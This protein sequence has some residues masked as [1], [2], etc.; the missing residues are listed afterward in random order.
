MNGIIIYNP[1][2]LFINPVSWHGYAVDFALKYA[3][4]VFVRNP[5]KKL[6]IKNTVKGLC[7]SRKIKVKSSLF[8]LNKN[9]Y[10]I[11]GFGAVRNPTFSLKMY[12]GIKI[13]HLL[14]YYLDVPKIQKFL[15]KSKIDYVIGHCQMDEE[16]TFFRKYYKEYIGKVIDLPFG[17]AERFKYIRPFKDRI[18][19]AVGLGSIN[20]MK[21]ALL[22]ESQTKEMVEFFPLREYQ[23]EVRK[24]LQDNQQIVK[25]CIDALF[26]SPDKQKDFSYDAVEMLNKYQMFVNDAGFSNF[27]PARTYEG[28]A[29]GCVMVAPNNNIY[30]KLGFINDYNYIGYQEGNYSDMIKKIRYY[31]VH[32]A[33][34]EKLQINSL[35]L[36]EKYSHEKVAD[37]LY[38]SI[39]KIV[40]KEI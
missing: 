21:D 24:Y 7:P 2:D 20:K 23:H 33:E 35:K 11:V 36:A 13:F 40:E 5:F 25:D 26:P 9:K 16:C 8:F 10:V 39:Q 1:T 15:R 32:Q 18:N 3:D 29:C 27:P 19:K 6:L 17:Y 22:S 31:I 37:R 12:S 30:S 34:L 28:I 4:Y 14:D 38:Q